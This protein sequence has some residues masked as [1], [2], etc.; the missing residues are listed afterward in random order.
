VAV[1]A[2]ATGHAQ[3]TAHAAEKPKHSQA[4]TTGRRTF[5]S[6]CSSCHGLNGKGGE[7]APDIVTRP[8]IATLSDGEILKVLREGKPQAGMPPFAGLGPA[9]LSDIL[10]YLRILQGERKAPAA[11]AGAEQGKELFF[12]KGGCSQCHMVHGAGGFLGPDLSNYGTSHA[13]AA[14]VRSAIVNADKRSKDRKGLANATT[15]DGKHISGLT[16]NEDNLS[17]QL[18]ALDGTFYSLEKASLSELTFDSQPLM[19]DGYGSKLSKSELDQLVGY[20]LS[21]VDTK[22]DGPAI[23]KKKSDK[24]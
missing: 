4:S 1:C 11:T 24:Q 18:Q 16:R 23:A 22:R 21:I 15:I 6:S 10:S 8:E 14:D 3:T 19:P 2:L 9:K 5:E 13:A 7:R 12:G 17:V 20:L